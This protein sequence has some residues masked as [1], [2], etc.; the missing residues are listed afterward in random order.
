M[1]PCTLINHFVSD[2]LN[3]SK[4]RSKQPIPFELLGL[5]TLKIETALYSKTPVTIYQS[6]PRHI[7]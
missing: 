6:T 5:R 2:E 7:Q 1:T 4:F 3:A